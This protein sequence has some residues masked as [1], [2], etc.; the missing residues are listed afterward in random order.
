MLPL[1]EMN[2]DFFPGAGLT[3]N[4]PPKIKPLLDTEVLVSI[5]PQILTDSYVYVHCH[6]DNAWEDA[7]LRIWKT[8]F[9]IDQLTG[10]KSALLH[11]E[12]ITIAPLWTLIPDNRIHTFLLIFEAL[13]KLCTQF[14]L[15]EI[16][17]QPGGFHV[18]DIQRNNNDVYHIEV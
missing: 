18:R 16:I 5:D 2:I 4:S 11:A 3:R 15:L 10:I 13:P 12:N 7:L 8:T 14:D 1:L 9:L 6:F 17:P